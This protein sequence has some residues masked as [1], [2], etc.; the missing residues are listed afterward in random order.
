MVE[1]AFY[2]NKNTNSTATTV[3]K[4]MICMWNQCNKIRAAIPHSEHTY[5]LNSKCLVFAQVCK[6]ST[7]YK[8]MLPSNSHY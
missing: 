4:C 7:K 5:N 3:E 2:L 1:E 6:F 8:F